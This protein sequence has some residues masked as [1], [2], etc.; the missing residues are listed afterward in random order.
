MII[1]CSNIAPPIIKKMF[2]VEKDKFKMEKMSTI[3]FYYWLIADLFSI[4]SGILGKLS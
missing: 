3:Y 2:D 1:D 4:L